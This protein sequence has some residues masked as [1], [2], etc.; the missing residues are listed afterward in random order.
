M[1]R[2]KQV[3]AVLSLMLSA[4]ACGKSGRSR[5]V[6][7]APGPNAQSETQ[8][9]L[10]KAKPGDVIQFAE[11]SYDFTM[12]LSLT[13]S[14]VTVRGRGRDKTILS[15]KNQNAGSEGLLVTGNGFTIEDLSVVDTKGDAVKVS[16]A[17][18]VTFRRV[19]ARWSGP[20]S[21]KNGG[22]GLYPVQCKNVLIE[23]CY[24]SGASDAGI[25]VGQS[26]NA[27]IRRCRAEGNVAG[28]ESENSTA[29]D[30]YENEATGN[31][32]G[33]LV[34][35]LPDLPV[36]KG[37][38]IRVFRNTVTANNHDNFAPKGNIVA[39]VP[40]GTGLMIMAADQVQVF[41]NTVRDNGTTNLSL[42]SYFATG[43]PIKDK[44]YDPYP[45]GIFIHGNRF[46]GGG[47]NPQGEIGRLL[48][49]LVGTPV[50]DMVWDGA[51][52]MEKVRGR[53]HGPES[54]VWIKNNGGAGFANVHYT[55]VDPQ[56][57][58]VAQKK[59]E[60]DLAAHDGELPALPA[61]VLPGAGK[62]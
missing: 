16:G 33:L 54:R 30:I 44:E 37:G 58:A 8:T 24:A 56:K 20:P 14:G 46:S 62:R 5:V 9:A 39:L 6:T 57:L 51:V 48:A 21:E 60:R 26:T 25:Y 2:T 17:D 52:N 55:E 43:K 4:A 15:F 40:P 45:E 35:D 50:P 22:Y 49:A 27:V 38:R 32:G 41:D 61:V 3:V 53:A 10:I 12:G 19:A 1:T 7:V 59:V 18:G 13:V 11:G 36:K 31:A 42:V 47:S 34:F 23:D 29:V 28:I